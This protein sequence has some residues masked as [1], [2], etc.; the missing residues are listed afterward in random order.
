MARTERSPRVKYWSFTLNNYTQEDL[1][2]LSSPI[3]EIDYLVYGREVGAS[4]TPHLQGT[5][6]FKKRVYLSGALAKL[7]QSHC[8]PTRHLIESI[9]Y[10]K[11][12]GDFT[13]WGVIPSSEIDSARKKEASEIEEFKNSVKSGV[14]DEKSLRELHST[15]WASS[16]RFCRQYIEDN[17]PKHRVEPFPL[18]PWQ[19]ELYQALAHPP[20]TRTIRFI[21]DLNGNQGKSWFARYYL[22]MHDKD[23]Q[24]IVPGRKV[25]MAHIVRDDTRVFFVDCPRSKQGE[26]IQYDFLEELKN[27]QVF[28][29]KYDSKMKTLAPPHI[30]VL[31]NERPDLTKLSRDRPVVTM[32]G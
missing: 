15:V 3:P 29:P 9:N 6:C 27:G 32:I 26:Y 7:G 18:R 30:V 17:K 20:D 5:A 11:K 8:T 1:T 23:T 31:M 21:V 19:Q 12:D 10:C 2:R 16:E 24:I 28:S 22:D 14:Y 4:G 13:E 25:D